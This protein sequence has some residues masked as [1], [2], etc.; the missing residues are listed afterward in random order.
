[1]KG[2]LLWNKK[3]FV[4]AATE[5]STATK[6]FIRFTEKEF[7]RN[8]P[9]QKP[10]YGDRCG[11]R[12]WDCENEGDENI[13]LCTSCYDNYYTTCENCEAV[14]NADDANYDGDDRAYCDECY[15]KHCR[16]I[17]NYGY[18]PEPIFYGSGDRFFGV[19]LEIDDGGKLSD[20][21]DI[22]LAAGNSDAEHIYIKSDGSLERGMEI[23]THPMT[24]GLSQKSYAV[25]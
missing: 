21:A 6:G 9:I 24:P 3:Y 10:L 4:R 23:V 11:E 15:E 5:Q 13:T 14:I 20:N 18:K 1:M 8:A 2:K 25:A 19:E 17:Q 7:A 16:S 12:I 22:I